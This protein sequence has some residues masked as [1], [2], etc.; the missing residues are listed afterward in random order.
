[1]FGEYEKG[2]RWGMQGKEKLLLENTGQIPSSI[3]NPRHL[4][5]VVARSIKHQIITNGKRTQVF[6]KFRTQSAY[7]GMLSQQFTRFGN[8]LAKSC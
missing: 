6:S 3:N 2:V 1:L 7:L 4:N 5:A 8:V